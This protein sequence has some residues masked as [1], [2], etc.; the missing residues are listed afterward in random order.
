MEQDEAEEKEGEVEMRNTAWVQ[1]Q[2]G[3]VSIRETKLKKLLKLAL[4]S[5]ALAPSFFL[6]LAYH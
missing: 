5:T 2:S 3:H 6:P 4:R 1:Q